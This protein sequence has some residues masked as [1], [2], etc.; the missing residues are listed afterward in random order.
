MSP[1]PLAFLLG[2]ERSGSTWLAN[3]LDAHREVELI[4]EPF[5]P[6]ASMF[7]GFPSRNL[8]V[9]NS[10]PA[11]EETVRQGLG[12][13]LSKKYPLLY[14]PGRSLRWKA[15]DARLMETRRRV[16]QRLQG[17]PPIEWA[18]WDLLNLNNSE[19]PVSLQVRKQSPPG[20]FVVKELR[21]N[22]KIPVLVKAVP[23]ARFLV[24]VRNPSAQLTSIRRWLDQG[25]LQELAT[26]L[27]T[28]AADVDQNRDLQRYR[29]WTGGGDLNDLLVVWWFMNYEVLLADLRNSG[30]R[31]MLI[32]HED[33]AVE[34]NPRSAEILA[35]LGLSMSPSVEGFLR[36]STAHRPRSN[37]PVDTFRQSAEHSAAT[38]RGADPVIVARLRR[39]AEGLPCSDD[40]RVYF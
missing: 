15:V 5:A 40:L 21:L 24:I 31:T 34:P 1:E 32:R 37:S 11:L 14:R 35:F 20:L 13:V 3:I 10:S 36:S 9:R 18:Q 39:V 33:L 4:M 23:N 2:C 27:K 19:I 12:N 26:A 25:R 6:Y 22:L 29:P 28:L 17:A 16:R 7:P 30:A 38:I 8:Y